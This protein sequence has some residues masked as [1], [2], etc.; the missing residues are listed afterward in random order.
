[1][2]FC[3]EVGL[4]DEVVAIKLRASSKTFRNWQHEDYSFTHL[5][6][7]KSCAAG[8]GAGHGLLAGSS[9]TLNEN[10]EVQVVCARAGSQ[11]SLHIFKKTRRSCGVAE[12]R[13]TKIEGRLIG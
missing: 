8:Y 1:M 2:A 11:A 7:V 12:W 4:A 9:S 5:E 13:G 6:Q 3:L 10:G